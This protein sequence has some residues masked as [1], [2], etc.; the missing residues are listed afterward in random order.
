MSSNKESTS[1]PEIWNGLSLAGLRIRLNEGIFIRTCVKV[2]FKNNQGG[3]M[4]WIDVSACLVT[5][6]F[7]LLPG[8]L[9]GQWLWFGS[10]G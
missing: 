2:L 3:T 1:T 6:A 10:V 5:G 4:Q 7:T 8:R 9:L